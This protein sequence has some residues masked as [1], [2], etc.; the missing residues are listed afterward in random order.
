MAGT[1]CCATD[2]LNGWENFE[3]KADIGIHGYGASP[4]SDALAVHPQPNDA[5]L[6]QCVVD[7]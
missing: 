2:E 5:W 3:H 7:V 1:V 6:A 4:P